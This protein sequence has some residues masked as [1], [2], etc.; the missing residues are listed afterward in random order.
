MSSEGHSLRERKKL[1]TRDR[2]LE[3]AQQLFVEVGYDATTMDDIATRAEVSRATVF[4]Y[5]PRKEALFP[6]WIERRRAVMAALLAREENQSVDTIV[7]LEHA[8]AA[9]CELLEADSRVTRAI[10]GAWV[11]AGGPLMPGTWETADVLAETIAVGQE[12]GDVRP[13]V[14]ARAAGLALLD[15]YFG[16]LVRWSAEE[17]P[18]PPAVSE[19]LPPALAIV[20]DG[21]RTRA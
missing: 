19:T 11:R 13:D 2:L 1:A 8:F 18:P 10:T 12:R 7:R 9:L 16:A 17:D 14:D 3:A 4:N 5:F 21:L 20:L 6:P 15:V